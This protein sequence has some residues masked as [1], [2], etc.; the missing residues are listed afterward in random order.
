MLHPIVEEIWSLG[1][2]AKLIR[3]I[4]A[5]RAAESREAAYDLAK[6]LAASFEPNGFTHSET[7]SYAWGR[8]RRVR[9]NRRFV[10]M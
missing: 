2:D 9:R 5:R 7:S 4:G 3:R 10:V 6:R 8:E 1:T